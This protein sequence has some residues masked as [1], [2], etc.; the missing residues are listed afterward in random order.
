MGEVTAL[1]ETNRNSRRVT[2]NGVQTASR[3]E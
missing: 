2:N 1:I 3:A